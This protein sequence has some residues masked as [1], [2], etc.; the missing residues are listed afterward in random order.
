[1][2]GFGPG[3][4]VEHGRP[5]IDVSDTPVVDCEAGRGVH[6]G[7]GSYDEEGG[8]DARHDDRDPRQQVCPRRKTVPAVEVDAQEDRLYEKGDAL[9][10]EG[11]SDHLA[12]VGH[13]ARPQHAEFDGEDGAR[14]S[15][16]G[17]EHTEHPRPAARQQPVGRIARAQASP[18]DKDDERRKPY[19]E[20][21]QDDVPAEGEAHL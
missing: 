4:R 8:R 2:G 7:V 21:G 17:K 12:V 5:R 11:E 16:H 18:L 14:H 9:D 20:A 1:M 15:A 6:P 19:S 10:G 13:Q 3:R